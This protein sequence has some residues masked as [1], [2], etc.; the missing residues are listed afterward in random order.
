LVKY[1]AV[2]IMVNRT[3]LP[4]GDFPDSSPEWEVRGLPEQRDRFARQKQC[5]NCM[6]YI[7]SRMRFRQ[8][9]AWE[10]VRQ[11]VFGWLERAAKRVPGIQFTSARSDPLILYFSGKSISLARL[12]HSRI[13]FQAQVSGKL[14]SCS[15]A[16]ILC[17]FAEMN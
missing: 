15:K 3:D 2:S 16:N 12:R 9:Q 14:Y 11:V 8:H 6:K 13:P 4:A 7:I 1:L 5:A 17:C 10:H